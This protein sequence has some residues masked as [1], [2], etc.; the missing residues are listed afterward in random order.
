MGQMR[1]GRNL[2]TTDHPVSLTIYTRCP[3]KW[4]LV[5]TETGQ[6]YRGN[7]KGYWDSL[8]PVTKGAH[9]EEHN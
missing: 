4:V 2:E 6:T 9:N 8:D 7:P 5:D 1:R 3:S